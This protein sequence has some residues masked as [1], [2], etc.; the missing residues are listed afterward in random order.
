M[1]HYTIGQDRAWRYC[2]AAVSLAGFLLIVLSILSL[3]W[4]AP[5]LIK[6]TSWNW[7]VSWL[8]STS[9]FSRLFLKAA[10]GFLSVF[11]AVVWACLLPEA[12][13]T[14]RTKVFTFLSRNFLIVS[15]ALFAVI[16]LS[17]LITATFVLQRFPNSGDEYA[18]L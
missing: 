2:L 7:S 4:G 13:A 3:L 18:Y 16:F 5:S 12:T 17:L 9:P 8:P 11:I 1:K 10:L 14:L 15:I 6:G